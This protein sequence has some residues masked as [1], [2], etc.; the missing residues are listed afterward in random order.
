MPRKRPAE[1]LK[2]TL[3]AAE[4]KRLLKSLDTLLLKM[5]VVPTPYPLPEDLDVDL[6]A[7]DLPI[8]AA[9]LAAK[10]NFLITGDKQHFGRFWPQGSWYEHP[11]TR[12]LPSPRRGGDE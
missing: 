4:Q 5:E 3:P 12:R 2:T 9:A 8:L 10:A 1:T 11:Q 6:P 7:K